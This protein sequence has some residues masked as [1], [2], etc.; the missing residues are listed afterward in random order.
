MSKLKSSFPDKDGF[1]SKQVVHLLKTLLGVEGKG[2]AEGQRGSFILVHISLFFVLI[3][4][5]NLKLVN[6]VR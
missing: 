2:K 3:D 4:Q 1:G 6:F 5:I